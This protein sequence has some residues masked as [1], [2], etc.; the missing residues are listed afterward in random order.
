[1][2]FYNPFK[3]H[4]VEVAGKFFVRKLFFLPVVFFYANRNNCFW[5]FKGVAFEYCA[6]ETENEARN[7]LNRITMKARYIG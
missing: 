7:T 5:N 3:W 4:I 6:H 1:M 2:K